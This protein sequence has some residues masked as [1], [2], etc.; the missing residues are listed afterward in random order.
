MAADQ[1]GVLRRVYLICSPPVMVNSWSIRCQ[2][3]WG[4]GKGPLV[5]KEGAFRVEERGV[6]CLEKGRFVSRTGASGSPSSHGQSG[7]RLASSPCLSLSLS[8]SLARSHTNTHR[9]SLSLSLSVCLFLSLSPSLSLP[10]NHSLSLAPSLSLALSLS[11]PRSPS[12]SLGTWG[13]TV[14]GEEGPTTRAS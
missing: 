3:V 8:L 11:L 4:G 12:R 7:H 14:H 1:M 9:L 10:L 13:W 2:R 6:W 5:I